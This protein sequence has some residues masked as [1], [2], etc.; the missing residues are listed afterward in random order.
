MAV[1]LAAVIGDLVRTG[2]AVGMDVTVCAF[3][4]AGGSAS[5]PACRGSTSASTEQYVTYNEGKSGSDITQ[6]TLGWVSPTN[7]RNRGCLSQLGSRCLA[8]E[9][10]TVE[11]ILRFY[12]G[13]DVGIETAVGPCVPTV[14][15]DAGAPDTGS[16]PVDSV[17][18]EDDVGTTDTGGVAIDSAAPTQPA[19]DRVEDAELA[20]SCACSTPRSNKNGA[21]TVFALAAIAGAYARRRRNA[22]RPAAATRAGVSASEGVSGGAI[23][24]KQ[25]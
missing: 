22:T 16:P 13:E 4:V 18:V 8:N 10:K 5:A 7:H 23:A 17:A 11:Q 20:G 1:S 2:S 9:G 6:T 15:P 19:S 21:P 12:Y 3:F 14:A 24:H 25:V